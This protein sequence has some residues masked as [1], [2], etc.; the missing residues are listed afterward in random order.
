[1]IARADNSG[2]GTLSRMF[3]DNLSIHKVLIVKNGAYQFFPERFPNF[4]ITDRS[5]ESD[6]LDWLL[7]D[8]DILLTFETSYEPKVFQR[9]K[10][11][12][13]KTFL[14]PMYE[15]TSDLRVLGV[16]DV[17]LCPSRL[18]LQFYQKYRAI[19]KLVYLPVPVDTEKIVKRNIKS[20]KIFLHNAGHGG[21]ASRNGTNELLAAI[22]MIKSDVKVVINSQRNI[23]FNHPKAEIRVGNILNY[24][25]MWKYGDVFVFPHKFDGLSLPVQEALAAGMPVLSTA[26]FPFT[27]WLPTEWF[28][29]PSD[30]IQVRVSGTVV[31]H[32]DY[33]VVDPAT[34]AQKI[35]DFVNQ[36]IHIESRKAFKLANE[37]SWSKLKSK[38]LN[39]LW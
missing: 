20:A 31:E 16:P 1:M 6:K 26:I 12:N 18:D 25:D 38:Y 3:F 8:I 22:P 19:T 10:K 2:L 36:D 23:N 27:S 15:C 11:K 29:E 4:P 21:L 37:I 9:A 7:N 5:I 39:I 24:W 30:V 17:L 13:I 33:A 35:D 34:I 14:M 28:F 32:I